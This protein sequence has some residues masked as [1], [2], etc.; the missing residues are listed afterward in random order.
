M[1]TLRRNV[2]LHFSFFASKTI[3][4]NKWL[5][6][7]TVPNNWFLQ[8]H[9]RIQFQKPLLLSF[10]S[11][12]I[13][14]TACIKFTLSF[15]VFASF[16]RLHYYSISLPTPPTSAETHFSEIAC[17]ATLGTNW[18]LSAFFAFETWKMPARFV[19]FW[20]VVVHDRGA[21]YAS[22]C[23]TASQDARCSSRTRQRF[24][25]MKG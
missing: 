14:A 21:K 12:P 8:Q 19:V 13:A 18:Q 24:G 25:E 1:C 15:G 7:H 16:L 22:E 10:C 11:F 23:Q 20:L 6:R 5:T 4:K 3:N 9:C 2:L 17:A